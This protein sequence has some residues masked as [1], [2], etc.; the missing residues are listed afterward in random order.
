MQYKTK[1]GG[2]MKFIAKKHVF[3]V[4][5][6]LMVIFCI[7]SCTT[8][9]VEP[10]KPAEK[11]E[12]EIVQQPEP[13]P[14][15][16]PEPEPVWTKDGFVTEIQKIL[17]TSSVEDAIAW[18][19]TLPEEYKDDFDLLLIKASLYLSARNFDEAKSLC[20]ILLDREPNNS[21]VMELAAIIAKATGDK[22]GKAAQIQALLAQDP[23][24][25]AANIEMAEEALLKKNYEGA[26]KFYIKAL[27]R[28]PEN[29]DALVGYGRTDY[30]LENDDRSRKTFNS[31]LEK[32]PECA[33]AYFY[34][35]KLDGAKEN[36]RSAKENI[37]KAISLEKDNYDYYIDSG[38]YS[39]FLGKYSDAE[40]A[41]SK[42]ADILP[43]YFLAYVYRAG[44]YDE[45]EKFDEA[46]TDYR[47]IISLRPDY[48]YAYE[49]MGILAFHKEEWTEARECFAKC[50]E[51]SP[52]NISYS[53][54]V[55]YC[56]Y[57]E[58]DKLTAKK[59]SDSVL[60]K[61]DRSTIEYTMLRAFHDETDKFPLDQKIGAIE[62]SNKRCKLYF[63]MALLYDI[64]NAY[65]ISNEYYA[66]VIDLNCPMFFE[67]RIAE[68][69]FINKD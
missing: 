47:K 21:D 4:F 59:F 23:Y 44:I 3:Y 29:E 41:W 50:H 35:A 11:P 16:E 69:N 8:N 30:F 68:W 43:D 51:M 5:S 12:K 61:M 42:A 24:N 36:Y 53:L 1:L 49:S 40:Q 31:I 14:E 64:V 48:Y 66:K 26:Q 56:Y 18:Y 67:Y 19:S 17:K 52:E 2:R 54:L 7:A 9:K 20:R 65:E 27:A 33:S 28:D 13:V 25:P 37:E 10:E 15:P 63:Y 6:T 60:R 58:G 46:L 55:T 22:A 57:K 45:Q 34:L 32:N 62:S 38:M 39:R